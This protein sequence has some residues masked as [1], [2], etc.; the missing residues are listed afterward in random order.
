[1]GKIT[2]SGTDKEFQ[3][4]VRDMVKAAYA[5]DVVLNRRALHD[6]VAGTVVVYAWDARAARMRYLAR[7]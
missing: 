6:L 4:Q 3:D 1:M 2:K 5:I 7:R